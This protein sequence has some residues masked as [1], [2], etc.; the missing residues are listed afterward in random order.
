[1]WT[2][3]DIPLGTM[4]HAGSNQKVSL[5]TILIIRIGLGLTEFSKEWE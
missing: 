5:G 2:W 4:L 1:M 3:K